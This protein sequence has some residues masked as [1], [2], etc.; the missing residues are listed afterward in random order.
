MKRKLDSDD[1]TSNF[2]EG[3]RILGI[4]APMK[5][6]S[7][8]WLVNHHLCLDFRMSKDIEIKLAKR[9]RIYFFKV[10]ECP[11]QHNSLVHYLYINQ[12]DGEYLL[13]EFRHLDYLWMLKGDV[14]RDDEVIAL[15]QSV[16]DIGSV[17]LVTEIFCDKIKN[18]EHLLF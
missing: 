15:M 8:C 9:Q 5:S 1:L 14:V 7:F 4:V 2:Y 6:Y 17:Q 12:F 11:E 3:V 18:K 16:R 13:P 10:Y